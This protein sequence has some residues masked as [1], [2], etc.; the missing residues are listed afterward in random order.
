MLF[1]SGGGCEAVEALSKQFTACG[2][3]D[4][5]PER[6]ATETAVPPAVAEDLKM[7]LHWHPRPLGQ[8][9]L[10]MRRLIRGEGQGR[11]AS[12]IARA[13]SGSRTLH[14]HRETVTPPASST[15]RSREARW[16]CSSSNAMSE[17]S[18]GCDHES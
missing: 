1:R 12:L 6:T 4:R 15:P 17:P 5:S 13:S 2:F 16:G 7:A 14:S 8:S 10:Q 18:K 11:A 9:Q 3:K